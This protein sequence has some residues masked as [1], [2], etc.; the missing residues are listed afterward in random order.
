[1]TESPKEKWFQVTQLAA[2]SPPA[3]SARTWQP[4]S[5]SGILKAPSVLPFGFT[6]IKAS[7]PGRKLISGR[8]PRFRPA[9]RSPVVTSFLGLPQ[10]G[11]RSWPSPSANRL[12]SSLARSAFAPPPDLPAHYLAGN[13]L[14]S[15]HPAPL[16]R[17]PSNGFPCRTFV[18]SPLR[19]I[20]PVADQRFQK[21]DMAKVYLW[22][23][24]DFPSLPGGRS[25]R[26]A[27]RI[28]VPG[29]LPFPR[30]TARQTSWN[31]FYLYAGA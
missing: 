29:P 6:E 18:C 3:S 16:R 8:D 22:V 24:P 27:C 12:T 28:V 23:R 17:F 7:R 21:L 15:S 31:H 13:R 11:R 26:F 1:V 2:C 25:I 19:A 30:L 5:P 14:G 9:F 4:L 10:Q 20:T